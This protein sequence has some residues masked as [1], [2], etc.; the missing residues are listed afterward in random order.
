[1]GS[2]LGATGWFTETTCMI[3]WRSGAERQNF[4]QGGKHG[5][6]D[7]KGQLG[8]NGKYAYSGGA[9]PGQTWR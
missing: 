6:P 1:M 3:I 8:L 4:Q 7:G 9:K 2:R 5:E